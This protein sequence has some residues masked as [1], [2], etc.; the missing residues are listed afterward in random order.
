[1]STMMSELIMPIEQTRAI[2]MKP[3]TACLQIADSG[4]SKTSGPQLRLCEQDAAA[5][6]QLRYDCGRV[7][8]HQRWRLTACLFTMAGRHKET[9]NIY[10]L[11]KAPTF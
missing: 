4:Q 2:W 8:W 3:E 9:S 7:D 6:T 5:H 10:H 11:Q 1:M